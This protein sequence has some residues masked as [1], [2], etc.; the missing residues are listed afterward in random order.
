ME[1]SGSGTSGH[2]R[3]SV[4]SAGGRVVH[5]MHADVAVYLL[6][7]NAHCWLNGIGWQFEICQR[8]LLPAVQVLQQHAGRHDIQHWVWAPNAMCTCACILVESMSVADS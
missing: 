2:Q 6:A 3:L 8:R 7:F 4:S 1:C 5:A